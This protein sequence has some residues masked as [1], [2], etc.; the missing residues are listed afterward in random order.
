MT[1]PDSTSEIENELLAE[2]RAE[3]SK[4]TPVVEATLPDTVASLCLSGLLLLLGLLAGTGVAMALSYSP[5]AD[6]ATASVAWYELSGLGAFTRALHW[7]ASNLVVGL[8]LATLGYMAWSGLYRWRDA[9]RWWRLS[10]LLLLLVAAGFTGQLLPYDQ[11]A[12]HGTLIRLGY[13]AD[14]PVLG[15]MLAGLLGAGGDVGTAALS[16]FQVLHVLVIPALA[17]SASCMPGRWRLWG[18]LRCWRRWCG[19]PRWA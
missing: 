19:R 13:V 2:V 12:L 11:N 8:A 1:N 3:L 9:G 6:D 17:A 7:H 15:P 5:S 4:R 18:R 16:R 14:T 10:G